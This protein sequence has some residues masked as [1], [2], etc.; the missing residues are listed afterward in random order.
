MGSAPGLH[1][2][3][4]TGGG[5][6]D[7][8]G[9]AVRNVLQRLDRIGKTARQNALQN[10]Q[11]IPAVPLIELVVDQLLQGLRG[12]SRQTV[13]SN[14]GLD[15]ELNFL[16]V[17]ADGAGLTVVQTVFPH[18]EV[19]I[20]RHTDLAG[21]EH[22]AGAVVLIHGLCPGSGRFAFGT[23]TA[24]ADGLALVVYPGP[25][26]TVFPMRTSFSEP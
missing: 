15:V 18:P 6:L 25:F 12:Q 10:G 9:G 19:Q 24:L 8:F 2:R 23:E 22:G 26:K 11:R 20:I 5:K 21:R 1:S 3:R 16:F 17:V 4:R 13:L 14:G 7:I